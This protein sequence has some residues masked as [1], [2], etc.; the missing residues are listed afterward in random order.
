MSGYAPQG[1]YD[2]VTGPDGEVTDLLDPRP[3]VPAYT[4][5]WVA[6]IFGSTFLRRGNGDPGSMFYT[7]PF[8]NARI[9]RK[10]RE[11]RR[12]L[13]PHYVPHV[14]AEYPKGDVRRG[15]CRICLFPGAD[16]ACVTPEQ[17]EE[18]N[19]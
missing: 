16:A 18:W 3:G 1:Y 11:E 6:A 8:Y 17:R 7:G 10:V 14:F 13:V 15:S 2:P 4:T 19:R 12:A 5:G 9:P